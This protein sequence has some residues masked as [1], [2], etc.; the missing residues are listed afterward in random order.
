MSLPGIISISNSTSAAALFASTF[1]I[2]V[3]FTGL[4][5]LVFLGIAIRLRKVD[6]AL[7][8]STFVSLAFT[9]ITAGS[10]L[11][12]ELNG[13]VT[14]TLGVLCAIAYAEDLFLVKK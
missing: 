10:I 4:T 8:A 1:V 2:P 12:L 13:A 6:I 7:F 11:S 5:L 14:V 3:A 9:I